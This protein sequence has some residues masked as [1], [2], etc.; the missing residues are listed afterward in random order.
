MC[1]NTKKV[2]HH[3]FTRHSDTLTIILK[4]FR[5]I[6]PWFQICRLNT[7]PR[8]IVWAPFAR[9]SENLGN[10]LGIWLFSKKMKLKIVSQTFLDVEKFVKNPGNFLFKKN[11]AAHVRNSY[12]ILM[13]RSIQYENHWHRRTIYSKIALFLSKVRKTLLYSI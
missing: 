10:R 4:I 3:C 1:H 13:C 9:K 2:D 11:L 6:N 8:H 5:H 7:V 12:C